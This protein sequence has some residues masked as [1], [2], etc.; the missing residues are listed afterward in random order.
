MQT[1]KDSATGRV[2]ALGD[3]VIVEVDAATGARS[4]FCNDGDTAKPVKGAQLTAVPATLEPYTVPEPTAAELLAAAQAAQSAVIDA[5]YA[6]AITADITY[7]GHAFQADAG[8]QDVLLKAVIG[9][10]AT[11]A[12]PENFFWKAADNT[13]VPFTLADL[14]GLYA[15]MLA[16]GW[17]DFQTRTTLKQQIST[18][19]TPEDVQA[20]HWS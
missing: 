1:F 9:Y 16:R 14:Q 8:S 13:R 2:W 17:S 10:G 20:I 15:A 12:V 4:F 7:S 18:A 6:A 3:E 19:A 5:A 11:G